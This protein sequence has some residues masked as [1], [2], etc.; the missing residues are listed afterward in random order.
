MKL[1]A[2]PIFWIVCNIVRNVV[3]SLFVT[4]YNFVVV[5]LPDILCVGI[6]AYP[7]GY[8]YFEAFYD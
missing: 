5:S 6:L 2:F 1:I 4:D 7:F 8:A 3:K